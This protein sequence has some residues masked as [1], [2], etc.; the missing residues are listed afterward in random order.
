[1][2]IKNKGIYDNLISQLDKI[3]RHNRQGSYKT[4]KRYNEAMKRFCGF[5]ADKFRLQ[6]LDNLKPAHIEAYAKHMQ[7]KG[8][9]AST[10]KTDITAIRFFHDQMANAKN[11]LPEN[12][13]LNL[14]KR[15]FGG[16]D[17]TWT[18]PE[19]T[20][21]LI[22]AQQAGRE[23]YACIF[24]LGYYAALR[25]EECFKLDTAQAEKAVKTSVL[26][27]KGKGGLVRDVPIQ[28]TIRIELEKMLAVVPRGQKLFI[29]PDDKTHLSLK[30]LQNFIGYYRDR[31]KDQN[32][33]RPLHFHGLR[34]SCAANWYRDLKE[35]G[36]SD[37][38]AR[39]QVSARLGHSRDDVTRIY[40]ASLERD[41][42]GDV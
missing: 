41:G 38:E 8:L 36:L 35:K 4:R 6:K 9:A 1:M 12:S 34:H 11:S 21:A 30:R 39:K 42:G 29:K 3:F 26:T 14:E 23:D 40:L 18:Q 24:C 27:V 7:D 16:V 25:I 15:R 2:Y 22:F 20:R 10:I 19:F 37:Y 13:A 33:T 31:I 17:R 5:L 28:A 32:S